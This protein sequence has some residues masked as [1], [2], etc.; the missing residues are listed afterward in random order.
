MSDAGRTEATDERHTW[1]WRTWSPHG[2]DSTSAAVCTT[3]GTRW[4]CAAEF[5]R[6]AVVGAQ[7]E[8]Q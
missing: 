2:Y 5:A 4:P 3:C 7:G 8:A 1:E 6:R